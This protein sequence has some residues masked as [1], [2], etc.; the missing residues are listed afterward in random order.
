MANILTHEIAGALK[1]K[2][3]TITFLAA[4]V[5]PLRLAIL[6]IHPY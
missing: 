5:T 6:Y 4:L 2:L 3:I 1:K